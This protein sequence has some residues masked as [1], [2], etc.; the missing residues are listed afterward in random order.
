MHRV[1]WVTKVMVWG[2]ALG[3]LGLCLLGRCTS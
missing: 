1:G 3:T 2:V